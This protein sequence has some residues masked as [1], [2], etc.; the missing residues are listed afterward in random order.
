M[1]FNKN[2]IVQGLHPYR[3]FPKHSIVWMFFF[4]FFCS[5]LGFGQS[6]LQSSHKKAQR[7]FDKAQKDL[8]LFKY[9]DAL[10]ALK[11]AVNSDPN[12]SGAHQQIGDIY[13]KKK[14]FSKAVNAYQKVLNIE[15]K[16][17]PLTLFGI[18]ESLLFTGKYR[19]A[20]QYF[21][22]YLKSPNL[23]EEGKT[24][25]N[26][27]LKDCAFALSYEK[28]D[29][30]QNL[31][32]LGNEINTEN[33]EYFPKLTA[34]NDRIIFTRKANDKENFYESRRD[35]EGWQ[36]A[37]NITGDINSDTFNEGSHCISLDGKYLFFA[38]CNRP[39]GLGSCDIYVSKNIGGQWSSPHNLGAPINTKGWESQPAISADGRSL[40]FVSTRSG[41]YGGSDLWK[42]ELQENGSWSTPVNLGPDIN[43]PY[44]ESSPYIHPDNK[45]L[46]FASDGWPGFG[47][48]DIFSSQMDSTGNWSAPN[49]LG[50]E[51]NSYT[52]QNDFQ[53]SLDGKSAYLASENEDSNYNIY[54]A[55]LPENLFG[56]P[57]AYIAGTIIDADSKEPL[58]AQI[59]VTNLE[60][61]ETL[62]RDE[63]DFLDGRFLAT[64][65]VGDNYA[66]HIYKQE[67]IFQSKNYNLQ[68]K[69]IADKRYEVEISL[70]KINEGASAILENIYF[71]F[72]RADLLE[73]S[74]IELQLLAKF[75]KTNP[76]ITIEV[77][78][79]TDNKG[80]A[81]YN[82][83][84]SESR[85]VS[86]QKHLVEQG[87]PNPQI[88]IVGYGDSRPLASNDTEEGRQKNRR[89]SFLILKT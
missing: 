37:Q 27:Y 20:K 56:T 89:T 87:I 67:Y 21:E 38:G 53:M 30:Q 13:R 31:Q 7:A 81:Q 43:T 42:S 84:L 19:D 76:Q 46:Y 64:L 74:K 55:K 23:G 17:L 3:F 70:E 73:S 60:T 4:I 54:F 10:Q 52:N 34:D 29:F 8:S 39:D 82:Q 16:A 14:E 15:S 44:N 61:Q 57:V 33:N 85:A 5:F 66:V 32:K 49:N 86:V 80:N 45:T 59:W 72:D 65:P 6:I 18:G 22:Q 25:A 12:F 62:F 41:G 63:S 78:G 77:Q 35:E 88:H 68:D 75:L 2:V 1:T 58:Q 69:S 11:E 28:L 71:E 79:H 24:K 83:K 50:P 51:I 26:K 47:Q 36:K 48:K 40:Y 9:D